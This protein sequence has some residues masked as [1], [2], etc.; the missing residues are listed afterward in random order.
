MTKK[1]YIM[2]ARVIKDSKLTYNEF[3]KAT[4]KGGLI[5]LLCVA[6]KQDN[7][8]FDDTKFVEACND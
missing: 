4:S 7:N 3:D 8:R 2:L 5:D 1:D 6:L